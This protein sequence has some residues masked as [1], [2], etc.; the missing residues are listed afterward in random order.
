MQNALD[1]SAQKSTELALGKAL[2]MFKLTMNLCIAERGET[3]VAAR[4][5]A[6]DI[7]DWSDLVDQPLFKDVISATAGQALNLVRNKPDEVISFLSN[8]GLVNEIYVK[9]AKYTSMVNEW[10]KA[11]L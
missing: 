11:Y 8:G 2:I 1:A 5:C 9:G 4:T 10:V 3:T 7:F 6:K